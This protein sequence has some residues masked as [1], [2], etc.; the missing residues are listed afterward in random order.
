MKSR[1]G[2]RQAGFVPRPTSFLCLPLDPSEGS[3]WAGRGRG[4]PTFM[5]SWL[6]API[7]GE[8]MWRGVIRGG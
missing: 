3:S 5:V 4:R 2:G 8:R 7:L 1:S 6:L